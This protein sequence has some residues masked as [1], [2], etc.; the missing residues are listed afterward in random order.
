MALI[1]CKGQILGTPGGGPVPVDAGQLQPGQT[2]V[3][4]AVAP[5]IYVSKVKNVLIGQAATEDEIAAVEKDP[6]ALR[7]LV[8]GWYVTDDAQGKF[9]VFFQKAFQQTQFVTNDFLDQ[10]GV[11]GSGSGGIQNL[12]MTNL[13]ESFARTA[14]KFVQEDEPFTQ[15]ATTHSFMMT[16]ELMSLYLAIDQ[17]TPDITWPN[18]TNTFQ[19]FATYYGHKPTKEDFANATKQNCQWPG[20]LDANGDSATGRSCYLHFPVDAAFS[21]TVPQQDAATGKVKQNS[22]GSTL[23][24]SVSYNET[25]LKVADVRGTMG[26]V[27]GSVPIQGSAGPTKVGACALALPIPVDAVVLDPSVAPYPS[28]PNLYAKDLAAMKARYKIIFPFN[29]TFDP[30]GSAIPA[31]SEW[32]DGWRMVK[33]R[34]PNSGEQVTPFWDLPTLRNAT[35]LVV[36]TPRVGYF[37]TPAFFANWPTNTS[38]QSRDVTN[39]MLIVGVGK[40]INPVDK[41]VGA[42]L[43]DGSDNDH[44]DPF[45]PCYSCHQIMDP[46]R[47]SFRK[48]FDYTYHRQTNTQFKLASFD[49][50]FQGETS[51]GLSS[52]DDLAT[53]LINHPFYANAW[54]QKLCYYAASAPCSE[55]DPEYLRVAKVFK[56]SGYSFHALV[57]ELY[58]SPLITGAV[59]S[60]TLTDRGE[61]VSILRQD[62]FCTSLTSRLKLTANLCASAA[63]STQAIKANIPADAYTRGAEAPVLSTDP[64]VF[65]R[66]AAEGLC[67]AA[68]TATVDVK[69][70][71]DTSKSFYQSAKKDDAINDMVQRVMGISSGDASAA[72]LAK[73]LQDHY[74]AAIAKKATPSDA[75][76]STFVAACL[77]PSSI[78]MGM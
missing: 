4:E 16:P 32:A 55:D 3:F 62:H 49:F 18:G 74:T 40:S 75:L 34:P 25:A 52:M 21:C 23:T 37:T 67:N 36:N 50:V 48:Y 11:P 13:S 70:G 65:Y 42:V 17:F 15:T 71:S 63:G 12:F 6:T 56:D 59:T 54:V 2:F 68:A 72:P 19:S 7:G 38:N 51:K 41:G 64:S 24:L 8:D 47:E 22:D 77:S 69:I 35:E 29:H 45:S 76:K 1:A 33:I 44:S 31:T 30:T 60:K 78:G 53:S 57:R 9:F 39:Q 10:G 66:S 20:G 5:R 14:K 46:M 61:V 73:L 27:Y 28:D 58:T 26:L 43:D